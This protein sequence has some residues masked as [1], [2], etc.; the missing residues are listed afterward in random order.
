MV[1]AGLNNHSPTK[2]QISVT[3]QIEKPHLQRERLFREQTCRQLNFLAPITQWTE[4]AQSPGILLLVSTTRPLTHETLD[5]LL[6][7]VND[8]T[9]KIRF[10][11]PDQE[12]M[13]LQAPPERSEAAPGT[14]GRV[15]SC[16][17]QHTFFTRF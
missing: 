15:R 1:C 2:V 16:P 10:S 12:Q 4:I 5:H 9:N 6:S 17:D 13:L 8:A 14:D 11:A 7:V 3:Y